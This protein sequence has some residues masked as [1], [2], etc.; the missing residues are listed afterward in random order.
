MAA[1]S[2]ILGQSASPG[3]SASSAEVAWLKT[4]LAKLKALVEDKSPPK[5]VLLDEIEDVKE[6][7]LHEVSMRIYVDD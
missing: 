3:T 6:P 7:G 4:E 2:V 5:M 1:L